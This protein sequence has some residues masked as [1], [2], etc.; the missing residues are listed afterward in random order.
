MNRQM[1]S[2]LVFDWFTPSSQR[3]HTPRWPA[4]VLGSSGVGVGLVFVLADT[5]RNF[6]RFGWHDLPMIAFTLL[7]LQ[8]AF[9]GGWIAWAQPWRV[10]SAIERR[11]CVIL[12][13][14]G[15]ALLVPA[16]VPLSLEPRPWV[17][18]PYYLVITSCPLQVIWLSRRGLLRPAGALLV[19]ALVLDLLGL[20]GLNTTLGQ[21]G[22]P[23]LYGLILLVGS[24]FVHWW[25]GVL[26][27]VGLPLLV[28]G[29]AVIDLT[30][31]PLDWTTTTVQIVLLGAFAAIIGVYARALSQALTTADAR[32][33]ELLSTQSLLEAQNNELVATTD[34][35]RQ[36][37]AAQQ[38]LIAHQAE[39]I[40]TAVAAM[41]QRS[42]ELRAIQT[43]LIPVAS[44]V[45]VVPLI[46]AWDEDR[47]SAFMQT[48]LEG[49]EQQRIHTAVFD[50]T[51]LTALSTV[52][53]RML[54]QAIEAARLL[55]CGCVV[56]GIQPA[57]AQAFASL[58]LTNRRITTA[59]NLAEGLARLPQRTG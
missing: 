28:A 9:V 37:Q 53:A 34:Q 47:A 45:L 33:S 11:L 5:V 23:L 14:I 44:G 52:V 54:G 59:M 12:A 17:A 49:V 42:I 8:V 29:L 19:T 6:A 46:G 41:Q 7:A 25:I 26:I 18:L 22:A 21:A 51:G 57:V 27:A 39:E 1:V 31:A 15:V 56:V 16:I 38:R 2:R 10:A 4:W 43:P 35:V 3:P 36:A 40:A 50:L 30:A 20:S 24:L 55:G 48:L 32:T 58:D 13:T